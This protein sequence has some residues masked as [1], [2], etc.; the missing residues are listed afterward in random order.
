MATKEDVLEVFAKSEK[1]LKSAEVAA[2]LGV[3]KAEVDKAIKALKAAGEIVSPKVC[4][5]TV[6]K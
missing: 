4:F 5:Y 2:Q 3:D 6:A 1:P